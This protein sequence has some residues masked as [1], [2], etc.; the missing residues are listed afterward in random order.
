MTPHPTRDAARLMEA[1]RLIVRRFS[2]AERADVACCGM[3][4]A[5]AATLEALAAGGLRLGELGLRLGIAPSTLS[6]NL[7]RLVERGLVE[8]GPDP[9]DR[10]ALR[11]DL[12][13]DGRRAAAAVKASELVF[14]GD[15]LA[16]LPRP[17]R[18]V[19]ALDELLVAIR[20]ATQSCCPGA[21]DHLFAGTGIR[22]AGRENP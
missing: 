6:R 22:V 7:D 13:E 20:D 11:A 1:I 18:T 2:L 10:R 17:S 3:T 19:E 5:Q 4:V 15:I 14:A 9:G 16:R 8:R 12:T 21:Y